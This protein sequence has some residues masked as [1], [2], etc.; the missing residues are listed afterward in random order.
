MC[1]AALEWN[2]DDVV[3]GECAACGQD[4]IDGTAVEICE[5]S[6]VDCEECGSAPCQQYC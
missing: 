1:C 2:K 4:T 3:N 5:Y 6:P